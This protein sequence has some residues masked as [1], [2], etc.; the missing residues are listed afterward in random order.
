MSLGEPEK[1]A[2]AR[3]AVVLASRKYTLR[4]VVEAASRRDWPMMADAARLYPSL[5]TALQVNP[6]LV[7]LTLWGHKKARMCE[8][9]LRDVVF[10]ARREAI[11]AVPGGRRVVEQTY[12][13]GLDAQPIV[14]PED[15]AET[16]AMLDEVA[17]LGSELGISD[18]E[19]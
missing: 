3:S 12:A 13:D 5:V 2:V 17:R 9:R 8:R 1:P 7:M 16:E 19:E 4:D 11:A 10:A 15:P 18:E 6:L 14:V